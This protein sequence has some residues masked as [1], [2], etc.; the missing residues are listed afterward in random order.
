VPEGSPVTA[1]IVR[2]EHFPG[3][4]RLSRM[5][6]KLETLN[7]GGTP[8][9]FTATMNWVRQA[10]VAVTSTRTGIGGQPVPPNQ[11]LQRRMP[12]GSLDSKADP[13][14][15][16]F[17]FRGVQANFIVESGLES[18]WKTGGTQ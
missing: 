1:R 11:V 13:N 14:I 2:L 6:V 12:I 16:I 15:G 7:V 10:M 4:P 18:D 9:P 3:P 8:R 5:L 17:D